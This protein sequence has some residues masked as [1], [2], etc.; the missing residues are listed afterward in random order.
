MKEEKKIQSNEELQNE[1][2]DLSEMEE[3]EGGVL[4]IEQQKELEKEKD[5]GSG[6]GLVCWC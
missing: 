5:K 3:V 4:P 6:G 2:L 1:K